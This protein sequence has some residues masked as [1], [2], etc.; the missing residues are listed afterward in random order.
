MEFL[1]WWEFLKLFTATMW[2]ARPSIFKK[3]FWVGE[4]PDYYHPMCFD[5]NLGNESCIDCKFRTWGKT[6]ENVKGRYRIRR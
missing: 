5:C 1:T 6:C 4:F 3:D 2:E